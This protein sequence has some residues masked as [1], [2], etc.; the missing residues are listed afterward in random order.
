MP[1]SEPPRLGRSRSRNPEASGQW[2]DV[3]LPNF[4]GSTARLSS[5]ESEL[6]EVFQFSAFGFQ[7]SSFV[8]PPPAAK[9]KSYGLTPSMIETL[10][11]R[12][13]LTSLN[14]RAGSELKEDTTALP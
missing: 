9:V 14:H 13:V 5:P 8:F 3:R 10:R 2:S 7:L 12:I 4:S 11:G 6:A 1:V